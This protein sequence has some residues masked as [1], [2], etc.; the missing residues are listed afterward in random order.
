MN[1]KGDTVAYEVIIFVVL[2]VAFFAVML[3]F[4]WRA[5]SGSA[6]FEQAYS[7][8]IAMMISSAKP[9]MSYF[10]DMRQP[11]QIIK[12]EKWMSPALDDAKILQKIITIKP[13]ENLVTATFI[14]NGGHSFRYFTNYDVQVIP[15][16]DNGLEI[17]VGKAASAVEAKK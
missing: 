10:F 16:G 12:S 13:E 11:I 15:M 2:N 7:K 8:E 6:I 4:I 5:G 17:R 1:K 3:I 9:G 14:T